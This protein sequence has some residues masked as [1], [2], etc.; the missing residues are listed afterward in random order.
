MAEL[1]LLEHDQQHAEIKILKRARAQA[2][3]RDLDP[4]ASIPIKD[5]NQVLIAQ[6]YNSVFYFRT[7]HIN[8]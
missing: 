6:A 5:D 4:K 7:K 3:S 2:I 8:I 1:G